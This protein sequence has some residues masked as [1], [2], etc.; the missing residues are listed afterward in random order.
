MTRRV[1]TGTPGERVVGHRRA[2]TAA[3]HVYV[4]GSRP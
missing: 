1:A 3:D 4:T 2:G